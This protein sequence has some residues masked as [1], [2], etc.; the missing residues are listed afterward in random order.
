M[1]TA[2][3]IFV[4]EAFA[5]ASAEARLARNQ[6]SAAVATVEEMAPVVETAVAFKRNASTSRAEVSTF[7]LHVKQMQLKA[8]DGNIHV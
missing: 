6:S 2:V 7:F 3:L 4:T 1:V 8:K 5:A